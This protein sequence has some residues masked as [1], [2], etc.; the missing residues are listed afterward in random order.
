MKK[1]KSLIKDYK[2]RIIRNKRSA[3]VFL[4]IFSFFVFLRFYQMEERNIFGWDQVDYAWAAKNIIVEHKFPLMG[5]QAKLNSGIFIGPLYYYYIALFYFITDLDPIASGI[6][7]GFTGIITFFIIFF[8]TKNIFSRGAAFIAVFLYTVSY[9]AISADRVEWPVNFIFPLSLLIFYS[10]YKIV[11]GKVKYILLLVLLVGFSFS[12]HFTAVFYPFII[13]LSLPLFPRTRETFKYVV[14]SIPI[15]FIVFS[16][17]LINLFHDNGF[18]GKS[19]TSYVNTYYHGLHL[20]RVFQLTKD[21]FIQFEHLLFFPQ[22]K[23]LGLV[24]LPLFGLVYLKGKLNRNRIL[25]VYLSALWFLV[26]WFIFSLYSGEISDYYFLISRPIVVLILSYFIYRL[27]IHPLASVKAI[28]IIVL[29]GY[30]VVN[31]NE[32]LKVK[33]GNLS[34]YREHVLIKINNKEKIKFKQG[35]PESYIYYIYKERYE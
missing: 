2:K 29:I 18:L 31:F 33:R 27:M 32:F 14:Y 30:L 35:A 19:S 8:V 5:T 17:I 20:R 6:A 25:F 21:A 22:L 23:Y 15:F 26:P 3:I 16:P 9:A 24:G 7:A 34:G 28:A 4:L 10:L 1:L 11:I 12:T 13:L